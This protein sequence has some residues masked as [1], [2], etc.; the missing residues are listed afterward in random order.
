MTTPYYQNNKYCKPFT[1]RKP[2]RSFRD[3]EIYQKTLQCSVLVVKDLVPT[4]QKL[5]YSFEE[6]MVNCAMSVPLFISEAHSLRFASFEGG[7]MLLEKSMAGCNKMIVYLEQMKGVY[8]SKINADLIDDLIGTYSDSRTK[9]F[10]L[11]KSWKRFKTSE[12]SG[13]IKPKNFKY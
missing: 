9:S 11:E 1:P 2:V 4:L 10:H 3:L 5:K 7:V 8:G 12:L 13:E 6:N